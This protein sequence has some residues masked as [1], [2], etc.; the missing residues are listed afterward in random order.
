M[1]AS[2]VSRYIFN[3]EDEPS[4]Q[5]ERNFINNKSVNSINSN[6]LL[7]LQMHRFNVQSE[8]TEFMRN[9]RVSGVTKEDA[10]REL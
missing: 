6:A 8:E 10:A 2:S 7:K 9:S 5:E 4:V 3:G 1:K